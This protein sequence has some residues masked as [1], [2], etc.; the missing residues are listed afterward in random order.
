MNPQTPIG[1]II[2]TPIQGKFYILKIQER[3]DKDENLTLESPGVRQQVTD[4]L[5]NARK[6][7]L[8]QAYAA[9]AMN[10][11]KII[12]NLAQKVV[13]S[14]NELSGARPASTATVPF[15][16]TNTPAANTPAN[17]PA[18]TSSNANTNTKAVT[19]PANRPAA[20]T[21]RTNANR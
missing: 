2:P 6:Q 16:N 1:Q 14:P 21:A 15:A 11:A 12:N 17:T 3:S 5:V 13:D 4:S 20:N 18:N 19:N 8:I 10:D 9:V 7:L